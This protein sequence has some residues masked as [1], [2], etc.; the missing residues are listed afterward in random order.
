MTPAASPILSP[1]DGSVGD[2]E[3]SA[4]G[5]DMAS[6]TGGFDEEKEWIRLTEVAVSS[7]L[8]ED[9]S[10]VHWA[11]SNSLA[12]K[13]DEDIRVR[14]RVLYGASLLTASELDVAVLKMANSSVEKSKSMTAEEI[15][16][17]LEDTCGEALKG[18]VDTIYSAT[19][20]KDLEEVGVTDERYQEVAKGFVEVI[21]PQMQRMINAESTRLSHIGRRDE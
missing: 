14:A 3:E 1:G 8:E 5:S 7:R 2:G 17:N 21:L 15:Q 10:L 12:P 19:T 18:M 13:P 9:Q 16:Q 20:P 11:S 4:Y 6:A